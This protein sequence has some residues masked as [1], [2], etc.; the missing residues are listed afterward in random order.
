[1]GDAGGVLG[2]VRVGPGVFQWSVGVVPWS[3]LVWRLLV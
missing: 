2:S 1:M 3:P